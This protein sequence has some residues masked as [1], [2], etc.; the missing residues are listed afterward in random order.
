MRK[1]KW[2]NQESH[3]QREYTVHPKLE[4]EAIPNYKNNLKRDIER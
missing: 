4:H 1:F 2:K 3:V